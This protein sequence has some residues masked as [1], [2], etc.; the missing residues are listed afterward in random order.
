MN[1]LKIHVDFILYFAQPQYNITQYNQIFEN[2]KV[3]VIQN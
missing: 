2:V 1:Y 3:S